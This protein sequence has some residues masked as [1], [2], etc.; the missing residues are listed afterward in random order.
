M[1]IDAS[2]L[3]VREASACLASGDLSSRDLV[4]NYLERAKEKNLELNA[5]LEIFDD[6][7]AQASA[8]DERRSRGETLPPIAGIPIAVK[9][10]ILIEGKIASSASKIIE[11]Y[12][13]PY[14]ATVV[15]KLQKAGAVLLGRTN[16]DEFAMGGSTENS[17]FGPTKNPHDTTRVPGGSSG[18]SAATVASNIAMLALGSDTGGSIRQPAAFC[19]VVGM[20]PSYGRVSR[21]GLMAMASSLDQI[22]PFAKNVDDAELLYKTIEGLD[23]R[24]A[25]TVNAENVP[26][27]SSSGSKK[28]GVPRAFI[29]SGVDSEVAQA[30]EKTLELLKEKGYSVIPIDLPN[31]KHALAVYY[32]LMPAEVSTN[33]A[34]F[35]GVRYGAHMDGEDLL[36]DYVATRG[37]LFGKET[38]RRIILGTY[39]L[40]SG[41]YDAYYAKACAIRRVIRKDFEDAFNH[42]DAIVLPTTPSPAFALGEKISDPLQMY[43]EDVFTVPANIAELPAISVPSGKTEKGL[44]IGFQIIAPYFAEEILF[45][46]AKDAYVS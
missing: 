10:N 4:A 38:K 19:G 1:T 22:G 42:I 33:L 5:Y 25:T 29:E 18:G 17:A 27:R 45:S 23:T 24:D 3:T 40:S 7:M 12:R 44:P 30:F 35:D 39:V 21:Y 13:A 9:D 32:I 41:Y 43:L 20:K 26:L 8:I 11:N 15:E 31:V 16:M 14:S 36:G 6:A 2:T 37:S 28:I 34:R 46:V